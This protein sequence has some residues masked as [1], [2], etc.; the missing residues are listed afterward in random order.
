MQRDSNTLAD[1]LFMF[2]TLHQGFVKHPQHSSEFTSL[3]E[4][5]WKMQDQPLI[6]LAFMLHPKHA[7]TFR[8]MKMFN[9]KV[10]VISMTNYAILYYKKYIGDD[11]GQLADQVSKWYHDQLPSTLYYSRD[12]FR[13]W[14]TLSSMAKELS[15]LASKL[16]SFIVQ[17]ATCERLFST[18]GNFVTKKR[19]RLSSENIHFLTHV[20]RKVNQLDDKE[21]FS[22]D[23]N[24][25]K[26]KRLIRATEY[27]N[28]IECRNS[29]HDDSDDS[30]VVS[31]EGSTQS[32]NTLG[33]NDDVNDDDDDAAPLENLVGEWTQ[34]FDAFEEEQYGEQ[35]ENLSTLE[36]AQDVHDLKYS[37]ESEF[38][39]NNPLPDWNDPNVKQEKLRKTRNTK[40]EL[41]TLFPATLVLSDLEFDS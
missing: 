37:D 35:E 3:L 36:I 15:V 33:E 38:R 21:K 4:K 18:F 7:S 22:E 10:S 40:I 24:K 13:F 27:E 39:A 31:V 23:A 25:K 6:L 9:D 41:A 14:N 5:R 32:T 1:V 20:K 17:T 34:A 26:K 16:L 8:M 19:N 2:G 29:S 12:H 28:I 11:F 30:D